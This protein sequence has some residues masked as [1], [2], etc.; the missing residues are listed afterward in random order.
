MQFNEFDITDLIINSQLDSL[1]YKTIYLNK[2]NNFN[3]A[4]L[5]NYWSSLRNMEYEYIP[6]QKVNIYCLKEYRSYTSSDRR[7]DFIYKEVFKTGD[8]LLYINKNDFT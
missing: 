2:S 1:S 7:E 3:N 5:N 8:I 6:G 4:I